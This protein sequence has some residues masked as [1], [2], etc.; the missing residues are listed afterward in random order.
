MPRWLPSLA[1]PPDVPTRPAAYTWTQALY[2]E[3]GTIIAIAAGA[4]LLI[5][6]ARVLP[7]GLS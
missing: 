6:K 5:L 2:S 3:R 7:P 1:A 4:L